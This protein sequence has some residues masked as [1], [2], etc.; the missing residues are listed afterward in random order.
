VVVT[1]TGAGLSVRSL[2]N[3]HELC[4]LSLWD[5]TLYADLNRDGMLDSVHVVTMHHR[6]QDDDIADPKRSWIAQLVARVSE[7]QQTPGKARKDERQEV[8]LSSVALCHVQALSGLPSTEELFSASIC[9]AD[10]KRRGRAGAD[11]PRHPPEDYEFVQAAPPL[12]VEGRGRNRQ[13]YDVVT[14]VSG[15]VT[16]IDTSTGKRQWQVTEDLPVWMQ[17]ETVLLARVELADPATASPS[18]PSPLMIPPR[19]RPI[20]LAGEDGMLLLSPAGRRLA[21]IKFPQPSLSRPVLMD[22]NG[23]GVMDVVV[24][25]TDAVWAYPVHLRATSTSMFRMAVGFVLLGTL[26]AL[27]RNRFQQNPGKRATDA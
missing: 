7:E 23:D 5:R 10:K 21:S 26:L 13:G 25:T 19:A 22:V 12:L 17:D 9:G 2:K 11:A 14:A 27:L 1:S 3:G 18:S 20:L 16:R 4:R 8:E 24:T 15:A 6:V